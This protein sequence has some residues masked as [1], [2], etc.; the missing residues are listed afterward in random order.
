MVVQTRS[1]ENGGRSENATPSENTVESL[2]SQLASLMG[3]VNALTDDMRLMQQR[4]NGGEGTSQRNGV[5][6]GQTSQMS[7]NNGGQ[8]GRLS[9]IEIP[10][11]DGEDVLG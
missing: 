9:K 10:K 6:G 3:A 7:H 2:A 11:F 8:Y 4:I 1:L 5:L